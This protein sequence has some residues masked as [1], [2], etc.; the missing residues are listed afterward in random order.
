MQVT[1]DSI[2]LG[3]VV[4]N[5]EAMV[6]FYGEQLKLPKEGELPLPGGGTMHRYLAGTSV[7][8]LLA[9]GG[10]QPPPPPGG[11][12]GGLGYRYY[13]ISVQGLD[14][15]YNALVAQGVTSI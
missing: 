13:T 4:K 3:I 1:K 9:L 11:L 12:A 7:I 5:P 14:E 6:R 2:D 15:T 10:N 8:K